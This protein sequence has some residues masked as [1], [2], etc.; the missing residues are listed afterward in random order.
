MS[1]VG[2]IIYCIQF[3]VFIIAGIVVGI[4]VFDSGAMALYLAL[5]AT[6]IANI[7]TDIEVYVKD[8]DF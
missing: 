7:S 5:L 8:R 4:K 2:V 3:I 1:K 6:F